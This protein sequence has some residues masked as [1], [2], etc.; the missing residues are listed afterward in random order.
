VN[1]YDQGILSYYILKNDLVFWLDERWNMLWPL[2][3]I[4]FYPLI[5]RSTHTEIVRQCLHNI[6]DLSYATHMAGSVDWDLL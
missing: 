6:I 2:Y 4:L 5:D 1:D 3:R